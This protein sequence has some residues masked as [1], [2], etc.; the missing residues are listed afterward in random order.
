MD[1]SMRYWHVTLAAEAQEK[2]A[3]I[4]WIVIIYGNAFWGE[5]LEEL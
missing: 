4:I 3:F 1:L 5:L 2:L